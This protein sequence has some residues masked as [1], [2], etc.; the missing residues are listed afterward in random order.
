MLGER[1]LLGV[2]WLLFFFDCFDDSAFDFRPSLG[3][4]ECDGSFCLSVASEFGVIAFVEFS[5]G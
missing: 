1:F 3:V 4:E 5:G 2:S